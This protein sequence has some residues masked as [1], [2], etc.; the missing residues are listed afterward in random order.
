M[1]YP[2]DNPYGPELS[3]QCPACL[4]ALRGTHFSQPGSVVAVSC[5]QYAVEGLLGAAELTH[6][7]L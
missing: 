2:E 5:G 7:S 1:D 6:S 4:T 3:S